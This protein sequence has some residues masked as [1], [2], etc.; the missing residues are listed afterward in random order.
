MVFATHIWGVGVDTD[1]SNISNSPSCL[2]LK[3]CTIIFFFSMVDNTMSQNHFYL[4]V[5]SLLHTP[6]N[7]LLA[8]IV[9]F[10][11]PN[12]ILF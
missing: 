11:S 9:Q 5:V 8:D 3:G 1:L 2:S 12:I 4:P 10:V 7:Q 6:T